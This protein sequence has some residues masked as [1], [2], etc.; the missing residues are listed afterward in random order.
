MT[1]FILNNRKICTDM[2]FDMTMLDFLRSRQHITSIKAGCRTGSCGSCLI[3]LG[4]LNGDSV[5]YRPLNSCILPLGEVNGKHVL[6]VE[7]I[8]N[9]RL[10]PIQQE[11]AE[12]GGVQCGYCTP[13]IIISLTCF[14]L[15]SPFFNESLAEIA[16]DG[17]LRPC[18]KVR[19]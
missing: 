12:Q 2:P 13:G 4:E 10:N 19:G 9:I 7:G 11:M 1:V 3:M 15:N 6:T 16:L 14:L 18:C 8:N 5:S 17:N